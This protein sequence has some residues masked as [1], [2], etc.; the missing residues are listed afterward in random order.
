LH[1]IKKRS[2][3]FDVYFNFCGK[4]Q[5]AS[6]VLIDICLLETLKKFSLRFVKHFQ[7]HIIAFVNMECKEND[8]NDADIDDRFPADI[9]K[10][11]NRATLTFINK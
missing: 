7:F 8:V 4:N 3:I 2:W 6:L 11:A 1:C 10:A 5:V 9:E